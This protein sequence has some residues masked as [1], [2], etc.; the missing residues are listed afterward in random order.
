MSLIKS[1]ITTITLS[2]SPGRVNHMAW[3]IFAEWAWPWN[4]VI[5]VL[6]KHCCVKPGESIYV[7]SGNFHRNTE[8]SSVRYMRRTI[9]GHIYIEQQQT[10]V[11]FMSSLEQNSV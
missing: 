4:R 8:R 5:N 11:F 1:G 9:A 2:F 7:L 6:E 3:V 10:A